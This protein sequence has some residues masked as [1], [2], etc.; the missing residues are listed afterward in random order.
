MTATRTHGDYLTYIHD[1]CRCDDCRTAWNV[2]NQGVKLRHQ[3]GETVSVDR[4]VVR[5][6]ILDLQDRYGATTMAIA[7]AAGYGNNS[8]VRNALDATKTRP[9]PASAARRI[10]AVTYEALPDDALVSADLALEQLDRL[11]AHGVIHAAIARRL[12]WTGWPGASWPRNRVQAGTVRTLRAYADELDARCE[13]CDQPSW[14]GGR[15]CWTHYSARARRAPATGCGTDAGYTA[16]RRNSTPPCQACKDA[17]HQA[18]EL[19][20]AS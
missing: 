17:H 10:L 6:H 14:G 15:W 1:R 4:A 20:R 8:V 3:R 11:R 7:R 9:V 18:H 19:R 13:D 5:A 2:Y 12:G 16:H